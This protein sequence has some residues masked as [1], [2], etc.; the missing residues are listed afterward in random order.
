MVKVAGTWSTGVVEVV[1]RLGIFLPLLP[2]E[3]NWTW[4]VMNLLRAGIA[5]RAA[6]LATWLVRRANI[7][8]ES[9]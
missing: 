9:I 6:G 5:I 2:V 4:T 8:G 7:L 1:P 3:R